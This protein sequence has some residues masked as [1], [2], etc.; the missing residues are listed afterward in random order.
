VSPYASNI[1]LAKKRDGWR[2][3]IDHRQLNNQTL[4]DSYCVPRIDACL[5]SLA[6]MKYFS[7]IDLRL[8]YHNVPIREQ[9]QNKTTFVSKY[10]A[11][12]FKRMSFG[13]KGAPACWSRCM[14]M[15]LSGL[16]PAICVAYL[17]DIV[18]FSRD[19]P[20]HLLRLEE[21]FKRLAANSLKLKPSKCKFL[22]TSIDYL[23]CLVSEDGV[24]VSPEKISAVTNWPS[25]QS[26]SEARSFIG[27]ASYHRKHIKDFAKIAYP[28][29]QLLKPGT[30]FVW[31]DACQQAM[32]T[33][34]HCLV[35]S[36]ILSLPRDD[37]PYV[38]DTDASDVSIACVLSQMY[39]DGSERVVSYC[40]TK[41]DDRQRNYCVTRRELLAVIHY[42]KQHKH[43]LLGN[44]CLVRT[45][46]AALLWLKRIKEPV[47]QQ[48]R[49]LE[50]LEE[51]DQLTFQH[52]PGS[53]HKNA[54]ALSRR[55][56]DRPRCCPKEIIVAP[57][58]GLQTSSSELRN[59]EP[60]V[61][62]AISANN[63]SSG[64][65][66]LQ[67]NPSIV[68]DHQRRDHE[69]SLII[70]AVV[71]GQ[72]PPKHIIM[73][74]SKESKAIINQ[75]ERLTVNTYQ[76]LCRVFVNVGAADSLQVIM[77]P[78]LRHSFLQQLHVNLGHLGRRRL[79]TAVRQR[80]Y[81]PGWLNDVKLV[82]KH[83]QQCNA[84]VRGK[85]AHV[86]PLKPIVAGDVWEVIAID[87][88]GPFPS[89]NGYK[90]ILSV[91]DMF[92]K[93]VQ[94][95]PLRTQTA[96]EVAKC[97]FTKLF[98]TTGFPAKILS[99][100]GK[101]FD[102]ELMHSLCKF[103]GID[104]I[105]TSS[106][107]ASTN[108]QIERWMK[109]MNSILGKLVTECQKDWPLHL[110]NVTMAYNSTVHSSTGYSP[111]KLFLNRELRL[112]SDLAWGLGPQ[113]SSFE[114]YDSFVEQVTNL[115]MLDFQR[116]RDT[117]RKSAQYRKLHYDVD[118]KSAEAITLGSLVWYYYP[119]RYKGRTPKW[120]RM[121]IGPMK[122]I[123]VID[124]HNFVVQKSSKSKPMVVHRDK[125][126]LYYP[127]DT[128]AT[129]Q[130][131]DSV[132]AAS[133][134]QADPVLSQQTRSTPALNP[135]VD[136]NNLLTTQ[137]VTDS[138]SRPNIQQRPKRVVKLPARLMHSF[139]M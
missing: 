57:A 46:H 122:V 93:W 86:T 33:L 52:R 26:A 20:T 94:V 79:E 118:L 75:F 126:K 127:P 54:D 32:D 66:D 89:S 56:C 61:T 18:C 98:P 100:Q 41:L 73:A 77:P 81:W 82:Y 113:T 138:T 59:T 39:P 4:A 117:L 87:I 72:Q 95:F 125:L 136:S 69:I 134:V 5:D 116:V 25:C 106:Y 101:N 115:Q 103:A 9:D 45:D 21:I 1:V 42:L 78:A 15:I 111:N 114:T 17:D 80:A 14:D 84:Y 92:S 13:L 12:R 99:D 102:S 6:G 30:K 58:I 120:Q 105:R 60:L 112:V 50:I 64:Q 31:T 27:L 129:Q 3:C 68:A 123:R 51:F 121:F 29:T 109:T 131:N 124:A 76:A 11:Y 23:G 10:G 49:W 53:Q 74:W 71:K 43:L 83:C 110:N 63:T 2:L 139:S 85:P 55:P 67:F 62:A 97:L 37:L 48:A 70:D 135:T 65:I 90:A 130:M 107:K 38:L 104:K 28:I 88:S 96:A 132:N 35:S 44:R 108:G 128:V 24:Q 34:K 119:R 8:A 133:P 36:P 7:A 40:S 137:T 16:N 47:G 22:R 19:L 91:Q